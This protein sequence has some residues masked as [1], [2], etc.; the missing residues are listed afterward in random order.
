MKT[1]I[2]CDGVFDILT[3][4]PFPAGQADDAGVELHLAACHECRQL[5][6]ALRPAVGLFQEALADQNK[7]LPS[8]VGVLASVTPNTVMPNT[9]MPGT[10]MPGR[11]I[12]GSMP[13][14]AGFASASWLTLAAAVCVLAMGACWFL[15]DRVSPT[16]AERSLAA[17]PS[18][19]D[20]WIKLLDDLRLPA[21]CRPEP[22]AELGTRLTQ[23]C[24]TRCHHAE[25]GVT[26]LPRAVAKSVAACLI[27]HDERQ[28]NLPFDYDTLHGVRDFLVPH[29]GQGFLVL[30]FRL[31]RETGDSWR[32]TETPSRL[33]AVIGSLGAHAPDRFLGPRGGCAAASRGANRWRRHALS[34]SRT[35]RTDTRPNSATQTADRLLSD[36]AG[37]LAARRALVRIIR[38]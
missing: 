30:T 27:C 10:V 29:T 21:A 13:E 12:P 5:A 36:A 23:N 17:G 1:L 14:H 6:E 20:S 18:V 32:R 24:C 2:T 15:G 22:R 7:E 28:A 38:A 34:R 25:S 8:Y 33:T 31:V 26:A 19:V 11:V 4:G 35:N 3:R 16:S 37:L 9:V